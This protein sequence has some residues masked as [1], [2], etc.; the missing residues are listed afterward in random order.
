MAR[1]CISARRDSDGETAT[2]PYYAPGPLSRDIW[3]QWQREMPTRMHTW[4]G[5]SAA[6]RAAWLGVVLHHHGSRSQPRVDTEAGRDYELE[7][8]RVNDASSLYCALGLSVPSAELRRKPTKF[9][10]EKQ[11][12][13]LLVAVSVLPEASLPAAGGGVGPW[14]LETIAAVTKA[15][16]VPEERISYTVEDSELDSWSERF[17]A[18]HNFSGHVLCRTGM[19]F[20]PWLN[21][22]LEGTGWSRTVRDALGDDLVMVSGDEKSVLVFF[23]EEYEHIA[24]CRTRAAVE[25]EP[26]VTPHQDD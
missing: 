25:G 10:E 20:Y 12:K 3:R 5:L 14:V 2:A 4:Q 9:R 7:G 19:S 6:E 15:S 23:S 21:F 18:R 8:V 24:F 1:C 22:R 13:E 17:A 16:S 11:A 26:A